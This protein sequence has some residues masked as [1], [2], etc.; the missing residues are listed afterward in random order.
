M[1]RCLWFSR[2]VDLVYFALNFLHLLTHVKVHQ[3][4]KHLL[5]LLHRHRADLLSCGRWILLCSDVGV[6][7]TVGSNFFPSYRSSSHRR[8]TNCFHTVDIL[9]I[10]FGQYWPIESRSW[11]LNTFILGSFTF[12]RGSYR[13]L[14]KCGY[15]R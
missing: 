9:V 8:H 11:P 10:G 5:L 13:S 15:L 3:L 2:V 7:L 14:F 1:T 4:G 6:T 12:V